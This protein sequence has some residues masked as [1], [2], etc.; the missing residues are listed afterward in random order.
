ML[1]KVKTGLGKRMEEPV[2][3]LQQKV[4]AEEEM[5][6]KKEETLTL[7]LQD[8]LQTEQERSA[9]K[10]EKL[11]DTWRTI[12]S[13]TQDLELRSDITVLHQ[14]FEKKLDKLNS[15]IKKLKG[16]LQEAKLQE[17]QAQQSHLDHVERL[18]LHHKEHLASLQQQ[19]NKA[20]EDQ[21]SLHRSEREQMLVQIQQRRVHLQDLQQQIQLRDGMLS[22]E[23]SSEEK[24]E[25]HELYLIENLPMSTVDEDEKC[26]TD[27]KEVKGCEGLHNV[28]F[29]KLIIR[30]QQQQ[31]S[32]Q[33]RY[34]R[35]K[36]KDDNLEVKERK[37]TG[38]IVILKY[39]CG[40]L[41]DQIKK[42][43]RA[44]RKQ[45]VEVINAGDAVTKKLKA[46][47]AKEERML[48]RIKICHKLESKVA[49]L[50]S[51]WL[52][53]DSYIQDLSDFQEKTICQLDLSYLQVKINAALINRDTLK[54]QRA[55]L[56]QK[57]QQQ[58]LSQDPDF[59][60]V[61]HPAPLLASQAP[62]VP[63][64]STLSL[65][66]AGPRAPLLASR[67]PS[68]PCASTLSLAPA[69]PRA[70]L[71]ASRASSVPCAPTLSLAPAGPR[72]P[73]LASRAPSVPCAPTRS[74]APAG[75]RAPLLASRAPSV[76]CAPTPS[77]APA[78]PCAPL[79]ASWAPTV[80]CAT[81]PR[82]LA[83]PR[84]PTTHRRH[85]V[86]THRQTKF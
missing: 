19:W 15:L 74:R 64:A 18:W 29:D 50:L 28:D 80:P 14:T 34:M 65:A 75:H 57:K 33:R 66:P 84:A 31:K 23:Q 79:L 9:V 44:S 27:T 1:K 56:I 24:M 32:N 53:N 52:P 43:R 36:V 26:M 77:R 63:C 40:Q 47:L 30:K 71:L 42:N 70:P 16:E 45:L 20:L 51:P 22:A 12:L 81:A 35:L 10:L 73:L 7:Y 41:R 83:A 21:Q 48:R 46:V 17:T 5:A 72:A 39:R 85:T 78:G 62:S 61:G 11:A 13:Q 4:Q 37:L 55:H 58:E 3:Q 8:K 54:K 49:P 86:G 6:K 60:V 38:T 59:A 82:A 2:L 69:G 76:P 67:A 25:K 68:V